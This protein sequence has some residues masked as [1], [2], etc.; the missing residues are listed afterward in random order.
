MFAQYL[1]IRILNG[2]PAPADAGAIWANRANRELALFSHVFNDARET[3][4]RLST[5]AMRSRFDKARA[6]AWI[7]KARFQLHDLRA[8]AGTDKTESAGDIR[9]AQ[10]QLGHRSVAITER[11]SI[12]A[13]RPQSAGRQ[14]HARPMLLRSAARI[15]EQK[16]TA[17]IAV[18][19]INTGRPCW[20]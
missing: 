3:G 15:A 1:R 9:Q 12:T 5:E 10:K 11:L 8:K 20:T 4:H 2:R 18:S 6:K 13:L 7:A 19:R 16:N 14:S 17:H